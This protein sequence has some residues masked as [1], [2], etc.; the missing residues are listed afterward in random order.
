MPFFMDGPCEDLGYVNTRDLPCAI[1]HKRFVEDLWCRF[2]HLADT[3]FRED[4]RN[5]FSQRFWEM[6]LA[7]A[8]LE[9]GFNL[10]H[11]GDEGPEFYAAVGDSRIWFEAIAPGPGEGPD[12]VPQLVS[13]EGG[14]VPVEKILLRFT[15]ALAE[16]RQRYA[17][18]LDKGIVSPKDHY[19]LA[20]NSEGI[21]HAPDHPSM[22]YFIQAF[23]G[24][25]PLT[26]VIDT[27]SGEVIDTF[28]QYRPE[29][30]K[31]S[32]A[33]VSTNI[34]LEPNASF[35]S[36]VLHSGVDCTSHPERL[37]GDFYVLHNPNAQHPLEEAV[38]DWCKQYFYRDGRLVLQQ[39][40][41]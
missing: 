1:E 31:L 30:T 13:G 14:E 8:L 9:Q 32:G 28:H 37:G 21:R 7:V 29:V 6:Y 38:F 17:A 40:E 41:G 4:A 2:H 15:N 10:E 20:I 24:Y 39:A 26:A 34:F 12:Q 33:S 27:K 11:Q 3:H 16:K 35:C 5:H 23:L 19:V 36:A 18:A 25:G 22:P